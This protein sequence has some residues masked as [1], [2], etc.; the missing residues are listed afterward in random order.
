MILYILIIR[1]ISWV[2]QGFRQVFSQIDLAVPFCISALVFALIVCDVG[3]L[4]SVLIGWGSNA[5]MCLR[6]FQTRAVAITA[7]SST[8]LLHDQVLAE[9]LKFEK[10]MGSIRARWVKVCMES[11][12]DLSFSND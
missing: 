1:V 8:A 7:A 4:H 11:N 2:R 9:Y 3:L 6:R 10:E 12:H 5:Y